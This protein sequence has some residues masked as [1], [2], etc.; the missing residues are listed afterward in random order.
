VRIE[1]GLQEC[2][3]GTRQ[4][5]GVSSG[6]RP[7]DT[8]RM[9]IADDPARLETLAQLALADWRLRR[10]QAT[11]DARFCDDARQALAGTVA[12][13]VNTADILAGLGA[14]TVSR[15]ALRGVAA[16][17]AW[18]A[19]VALSSYA[20][21]YVDTVQAKAPLPQYLALVYGGVVV[22]ATRAPALNGATPESV[23]D[24]LAPA[25]PEWEPDALYAALK[26]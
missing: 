19:S 3:G 21:G 4:P 12:Q 13:Q 9:R 2:P 22:P 5:L 26:Q 8:V 20:L 6:D 25:Y 24:R 14:A 1:T 10:A 16:D 11:G 15:D 18:P 7:R 17:A 23:V